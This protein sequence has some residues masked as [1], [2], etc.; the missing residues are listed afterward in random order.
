MRLVFET[1]GATNQIGEVLQSASLRSKSLALASA[2]LTNWNLGPMADQ[3]KCVG[4]VRILCG[5]VL[6]GDTDP[7]LAEELKKLPN[8]E[9]RFRKDLHAKVAITENNVIIGSANAT[10]NGFGGGRM[11]AAAVLNSVR[12]RREALK[13]FDTLW[14][15]RDSEDARV[16]EPQ[17]W[18]QARAVWDAK[19]PPQ[20]SKPHFVDLF[21]SGQLS[22]RVS[23][24]FYHDMD[25]GLSDENAWAAIHERGRGT[26]GWAYQ[27]PRLAYWVESQNPTGKR[28]NGILKSIRGVLR[29][30]RGSEVICFLVRLD[31]NDRIAQFLLKGTYVARPT[32]ECFPVEERGCTYFVS[33]Y[34]IVVSR[35]LPFKIAP[36]SERTRDFLRTLQRSLKRNS[37][38]W[39]RYASTNAGQYLYCTQAKLK[40][41]L[42]GI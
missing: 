23:F 18:E 13:W 15:L 1:P 2:Y 17:D 4:H 31:N 6:S 42:D 38:A 30:V 33:L 26:N 22:P 12:A 14:D 21:Y 40:S 19:N 16:L 8:V 11:D 20:G 9:I 3:F 27:D 10:S 39:K 41:L 25:T 36:G 37:A 5:H 34:H 35:A 24:A 32:G 29:Q 7:R 28:A